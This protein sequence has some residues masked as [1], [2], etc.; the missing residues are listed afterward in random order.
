MLAGKWHSTTSLSPKM[1]SQICWIKMVT[2]NSDEPLNGLGEHHFE[3]RTTKWM[4]EYK[5]VTSSNQF[6][7]FPSD[8]DRETN[9]GNAIHIYTYIYVYCICICICIHTYIRIH[10]VELV[11]ITS[12]SLAKISPAQSHPMGPSVAAELLASHPRFHTWCRPGAWWISPHYSD[13]PRCH[14]WHHR[15]PWCTT[16]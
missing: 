2:P 12:T 4:V 10:I 5:Q 6:C 13:S 3:K 8:P 9:D 14:G 7:P 1:I 11:N 15:A 16:I